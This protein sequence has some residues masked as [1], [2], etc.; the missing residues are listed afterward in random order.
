MDGRRERSPG[1]G[2]TREGDHFKREEVGEGDGSRGGL[3]FYRDVTVEGVM[4]GPGGLVVTESVGSFWEEF[5]IN[6]PNDIIT[7]KCCWVF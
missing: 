7:L 3:W 1:R 4:K 5:L 6:S 2:V